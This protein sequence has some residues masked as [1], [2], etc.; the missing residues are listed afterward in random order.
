MGSPCAACRSSCPPTPAAS[1]GKVESVL[2]PQ[3]PIECAQ[4][5]NRRGAK[6]SRPE[7]RVRRAA[8]K[9][10]TNNGASI[11]RKTHRTNS[12]YSQLSLS[13]SLKPTYRARQMIIQALIN[14]VVVLM[15]LWLARHVDCAAYAGTIDYSRIAW[16]IDHSGSPSPGTSIGL[17]PARAIQ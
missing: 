17:T 4:L 3:D 8:P 7:V 13:G 6:S 14:A 10:T 1:L 9:L 12:P 2:L 11:A 15:G 5:T 16:V